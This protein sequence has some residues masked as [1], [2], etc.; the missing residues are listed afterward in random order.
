MYPLRIVSH[1][2]SSLQGRTRRALYCPRQNC[3]SGRSSK[4]NLKLTP[5]VREA[6]DNSLLCTGCASQCSSGARAD[7]VIMAVRRTFADELGLPLVKKALGKTLTQ[8]GMALDLGARIDAVLQPLV[9]RG[10]PED[11]G[12]L[13]RFALPLVDGNQYVP[14]VASKPLRSRVRRAGNAGQPEVIYFTGYMANYA[15]TEIADNTVKLLNT[16]GVTVTV[17]EKQACCGMPMLVS[18][19]ADSVRKQ[20][21]RNVKALAGTRGPIVVTCASCGHMLQHGYHEVLGDNAELKADLDDIAARTTDIIT[22]LVNV[23]GEEQLSRLLNRKKPATVTYHD[24]CHL[25]KAQGVTEE[26]RK[27]PS[28][29]PDVYCKEMKQPEACYGLGGTYCIAHMERSKSIQAKKIDDAQQPVQ[30]ALPQ[31]AQAVSCYCVTVSGV[32]LILQCAQNTS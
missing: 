28:L 27:L 8:P 20:A 32:A 7:K 24:P 22:Y 2:L 11:S 5:R 21:E 16:A 17:P 26:P 1:G 23:V 4:G 25:R 29:I 30:T 18:R 6:F 10:I 13:P 9:F 3:H 19:D 15:M 31:P 14:K 12:L